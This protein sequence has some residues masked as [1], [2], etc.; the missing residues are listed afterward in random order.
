MATS[1]PKPSLFFVC[2][3]CYFVSFSPF[4]SLLLM[5][6]PVFPLE[7]GIFGLFFSVSLCFSLAFFGLP[8]FKCL[9]LCLSPALFSFFTSFL[10]FCSCFLLVP[11]FSLFLSLF[12]FFCFLC[13]L[14]HERNNIKILNCKVFVSSILS[15]C[16]LP[17]LF[18]L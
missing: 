5:E 7:K 2:L 15:L 17:V 10:S 18:S 13:L 14:F 8:L 9:F 11:C 4:L 6:K 16:W 1:G 3:L 12:L